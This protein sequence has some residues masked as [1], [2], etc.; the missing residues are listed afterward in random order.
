MSLV[1]RPTW[2]AWSG[3]A[4][5]NCSQW[6]SFQ[7]TW[8]WCHLFEGQPDR[9]DLGV[10]GVTAA[11]GRVCSVHD[12]NHS[13]G[14]QA[15]LIGMIWACY[16]YVQ[17][18]VVARSMTRE[19]H[20]DPDTEVRKWTVLMRVCVHLSLPSPSLPP[21]YLRTSLVPLLQPVS[22]SLSLCLSL[23][24]T[25][26]HTHTHSFIHTHTH[27]HTHTHPHISCFCF[28]MLLPPRYEDAIKIQG[29]T[30]PPPPPYS[31]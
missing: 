25:H 16:K 11:S 19:Y 12:W 2:P 21:S 18:L 6:Q 20:V 5:C 13:P 31:Q 8:L 24:L 27:T 10:L 15:Y 17:Q 28:Q 4:R 26:T 23:S 30:Q 22:L 3:C 7:W 29:N 9:H 14:L 1:W